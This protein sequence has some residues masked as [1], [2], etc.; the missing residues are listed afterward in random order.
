MIQYASVKTRMAR[1]I[2]SIICLVGNV[3]IGKHSD[4]NSNVAVCIHPLTWNHTGHLPYV[5]D[6]D[7]L[8]IVVLL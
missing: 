4:N 6:N 1:H 3:H 2:M 8:Q 7:F 5:L